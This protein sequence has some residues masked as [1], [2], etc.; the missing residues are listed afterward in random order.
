MISSIDTCARM[1][2]ERKMMATVQCQ[3]SNA[4]EF[5]ILRL[6]SFIGF[7][8]P[9]VNNKKDLLF[10][11]FAMAASVSVFLS[12]SVVLFP[13]YENPMNK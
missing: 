5:T 3:N 12:V 6:S 2:A 10:R 11:C 7:F 4:K 13:L 8:P 9:K 1:K